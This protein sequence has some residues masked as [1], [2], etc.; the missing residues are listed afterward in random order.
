MKKTIKKKIGII[1]LAAIFLFVFLLTL[2]FLGLLGALI[3]WGI[4][5]VFLGLITLGLWL[6]FD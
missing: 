3:F 4:M 1:L 6:I 2:D 5:V